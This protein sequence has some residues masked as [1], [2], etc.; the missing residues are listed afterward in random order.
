VRTLP[1][2]WHVLRL[3]GP[4][5]QRVDLHCIPG[6][7]SALAACA[8]L[9]TSAPGDGERCARTIEA[10]QD[11][12]YDPAAYPGDLKTRNFTH[13]SGDTPSKKSGS[14]GIASALRFV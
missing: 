13:V 11:H 14:S 12:G 1:G 6:L 9:N 4:F 8:E 5:V 10:S 7:T 2:F 3:A